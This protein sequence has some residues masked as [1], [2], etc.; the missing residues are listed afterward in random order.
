MVLHSNLFLKPLAPLPP[1]LIFNLQG[2]TFVS[3]PL[4]LYTR[5]FTSGAL[6]TFILSN[7]A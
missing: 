3:N 2:V 4:K 6:L 1:T 5:Y 7:L